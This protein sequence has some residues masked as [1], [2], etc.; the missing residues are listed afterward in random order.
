MVAVPAQNDLNIGAAV[1]FGRHITRCVP[2]IVRL[3][4]GF[5]VERHN[6]AVDRDPCIVKID[7]QVAVVV[8]LVHVVIAKVNVSLAV[9]EVNGHINVR[10]EVPCFIGKRECIIV[11]LVDEF[12]IVVVY[13]GN[14]FAANLGGIEPIVVGVKI[15]IT[16]RKRLPGEHRVHE[17]IVEFKIRFRE[18]DAGHFKACIAVII[19]P[20]ARK[21]DCNT[22][23][24]LFIGDVIHHHV[25]NGGLHIVLGAE[26]KAL[27]CQRGEVGKIDL[28]VFVVAEF[29]HVAAHLRKRTV[30]AAL[31]CGVG[32]SPVAFQRGV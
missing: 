14:V 8:K 17:F 6:H 27:L 18:A 24:G 11:A 26:G 25:L 2:I 12:K 13:C 32:A 1:Q 19:R 20:Q 10:D 15:D 5:G 23:G 9:V 30:A 29:P 16:L 28:V 22:R 7:F 4:L 3:F 31:Q 21:I